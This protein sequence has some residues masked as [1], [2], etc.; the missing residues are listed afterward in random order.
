MNKIL[1][2]TIVGS[3][4]CVTFVNADKSDVSVIEEPIVVVEQKSNPAEVYYCPLTG[5]YITAGVG[6]N[7]YKHELEATF[8]DDKITDSDSVGRFVGVL[9][10]GGG[11]AF[12]ENFYVGLEAIFDFFSSKD[13]DWTFDFD[14]TS[15]TTKV[16]TSAENLSFALRLGYFNKSME[17]L[18]YAKIAASHVSTTFTPSGDA[19]EEL[20]ES[21]STD[22]I[23]IS[24]LSPAVALGV[25]KAFTK[26]ISGRLECEYKFG[27]NKAFENRE[28]RAELKTASGINVRALVSYNING[29]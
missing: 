24:K 2:S 3:L 13:K 19:A 18:F 23:K 15:V 17:T 28:S 5:F 8:G 21:M 9:G 4:F 11:K 22:S 25:E 27:A 20:F 16:N 10:L 26:K 7:F 12:D 14:N 29:L 6:G 1:L